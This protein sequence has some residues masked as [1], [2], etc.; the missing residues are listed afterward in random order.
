MAG[1]IPIQ[2]FLMV[3]EAYSAA[4]NN[5]FVFFIEFSKRPLEVF[6]AGLEQGIY[7]IGRA[8]VANVRHATGVSQILQNVF[9]QRSLRV[10]TRGREAQIDTSI[11][12]DPLDIATQFTPRCDWL[13]D[14][15]VV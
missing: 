6:L 11:R 4:T 7:F 2:V 12:S 1:V 8:L 3:Y 5:N 13:E 15:T 9:F 10:D 14:I